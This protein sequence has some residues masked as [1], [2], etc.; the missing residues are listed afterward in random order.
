METK[1]N[2][3][4]RDSEIDATA[5]DSI[6]FIKIHY[7]HVVYAV[8]KHFGAVQ[9][10]NWRSRKKSSTPWLMLTSLSSQ[11]A[12]IHNLVCPVLHCVNAFA[13]LSLYNMPCTCDTRKQICLGKR[14]NL[15]KD[16]NQSINPLESWDISFVAPIQ[17][18]CTYVLYDDSIR[19]QTKLLCACSC[20]RVVHTYR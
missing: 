17:I 15:Q 6:Q 10:R 11:R 20:L 1:R 18:Y 4:K 19:F 16:L 5:I 2:E 13:S 3:R 14:Q 12:I 8:F 9:F 7:V